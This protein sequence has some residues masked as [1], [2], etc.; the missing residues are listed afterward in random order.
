[1]TTV[2]TLLQVP[3]QYK[4]DEHPS[5]SHHGFRR[6]LLQSIQAG[7]HHLCAAVSCRLC[8]CLPPHMSTT[9]TRAIAAPTPPSTGWDRC[10]CSGRCIVPEQLRAIT[11][12]TKFVV[13]CRY[14][15]PRNLVPVAAVAEVPANAGGS[16]GGSGLVE[17]PCCQ[18]FRGGG[19]DRNDELTRYRVTSSTVHDDDDDAD[20][21]GMVWR[22][23]GKSWRVAFVPHL[24]AWCLMTGYAACGQ[25]NEEWTLFAESDGLVVY[26]ARYQTTVCAALEQRLPSALVVAVV[27]RLLFG[28]SDDDDDAKYTDDSWQ[29]QLADCP[30]AFMDERSTAGLV[31]A[32]VRD[33][34][35]QSS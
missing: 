30:I 23:A 20:D 29:V 15:L 24:R 3:V 27:R 6:R 7:D 28:Q 34:S 35:E 19:G 2:G 4:E 5:V 33:R 13:A 31:F 17:A 22:T 18:L 11:A 14:E 21:E 16:G 25:E 8:L 26:D 1:V 10:C 9:T 32:L 12:G